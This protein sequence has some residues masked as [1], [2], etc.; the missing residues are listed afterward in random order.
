MEEPNAP[1]EKSPSVHDLIVA[2][3]EKDRPDFE[4]L[5]TAFEKKQGRI[6][7]EYYALNFSAAL[8][9][10]AKRRSRWWPGV[11]YKTRLFYDPSHSTPEF[12]AVFR[13]ARPVER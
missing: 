9:L 7:E 1:G 10:V 11:V 4:P 13:S 12:D 8:L 2:H 5:R 3:Q 6:L